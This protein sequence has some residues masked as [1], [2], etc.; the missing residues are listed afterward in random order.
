MAQSK[1]R[2][3]LQS[4]KARYPTAS[5]DELTDRF[6]E[7]LHNDEKRHQTALEEVFRTHG[8]RARASVAKKRVAPS[9][10]AVSPHLR[11]EVAAHALSRHCAS[12]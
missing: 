5:V 8:Q 4:L 10:A 11:D 1:L 3:L 6:M 7:E 12:H 2:E 9:G